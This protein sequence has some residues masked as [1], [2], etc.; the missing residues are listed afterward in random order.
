LWL[1]RLEAFASALR[2]LATGGV[3][4]LNL[5]SFAIGFSAIGGALNGL[6][7]AAKAARGGGLHG[8]GL[9]SVGQGFI[10]S[11]FSLLFLLI[12]P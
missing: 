11:L 5:S 4:G 12:K 1:L 8:G 7:G 9:V 6:V 10:S 2:R 3:L